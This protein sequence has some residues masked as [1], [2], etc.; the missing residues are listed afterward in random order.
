MGGGGGA[1]SKINQGTSKFDPVLA[2]IIYEWYM[3]KNGKY[4]LDPF[5]GGNIRGIMAELKGYKYI[6]FEVRKE[7]VEI[8]IEHAKQVGVEPKFIHDSSLNVLKYFNQPFFDM[9]FTCP[10]YYNLEVYSTQD[11]DLS[12]YPSYEKFLLDYEKILHN[13]SFLLNSN[14]FFV[15]VVS[16]VRDEKGEYRGLV[17]DTIRILKKLGLTFYN[18][19]I[20]I[21]S[22]GTAHLR[23]SSY[24]RT[25]KV[26][27]VHQ[28]VLVFYK[29]DINKIK[30]LYT[31]PN[32]KQYYFS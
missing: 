18:D 8:D 6:G 32:F 29:G 16:D 27:R 12:A 26:V 14:S 3:K 21:N 4:V 28:H 30:E 24:F 9:V 13:C 5:S 19:I 10:P 25:R 1:I 22:H 11:D 15:I 31:S 23:A 2:E 20:Y 7:Q 17:C